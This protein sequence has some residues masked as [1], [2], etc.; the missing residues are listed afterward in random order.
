MVVVDSFDGFK[1]PRDDAIGPDVS[2]SLQERK[3]FE[4]RVVVKGFT[5]EAVQEACDR[6]K[7]DGIPVVYLPEGRYVL[8]GV[9]IPGGLT[10]LGAGSK[11]LIST[12]KD[13]MIFKVLGD[14]V[15]ITHMKMYGGNPTP[16]HISES[17]C[18]QAYEVKNIRV[19]HCEV[20]AFARAIWFGRGAIAQVDHCIIHHNCWS[21][22]GYGVI[23]VGDGT[24]VLVCD[25]IFHSNR[26]TVTSNYG[27]P[28]YT[29][30][31]NH[32]LDDKDCARRD[33]LSQCDVHSE[34]TEGTFVVE[35]NM[36][37]NLKGAIGAWAGAFIVRGNLFRNVGY[38]IW[39]TSRR[40]H[41][42]Q[43][44][45]IF[46]NV[47]HRYRGVVTGVC[48]GERPITIPYMME[49]DETG[50]IKVFEEGH[51]RLLHRLWK[52]TVG[53]DTVKPSSERT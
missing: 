17:C 8:N 27:S 39:I 7:K 11:T 43:D 32:I 13:G 21:G 9:K 4:R 28:H 30:R 20:S 33:N 34:A 6:A 25:N 24:R 48:K 1:G 40:P 41:E 45:N 5:T 53:A 35:Y 31:H 47:K 12:V 49:M 51:N 10:L 42:I 18:L 3:A 44:N 36:F 37:E 15:R 19:D 16:A 50:V 29:F 38:A 26:H 2:L 22:L 23:S 14:K 52:G 46:E